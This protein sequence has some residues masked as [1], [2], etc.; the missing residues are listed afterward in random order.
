MKNFN[1]IVEY[2]FMNFDKKFI[3]DTELTFENFEKSNFKKFHDI[4][5]EELK[6]E[7]E[8]NEDKIVIKD[9]SDILS[10]RYEN[11]ILP[12]EEEYLKKSFENK[13]LYIEKF[14]V[15]LLKENKPYSYYILNIFKPKDYIHLYEKYSYILIDKI[16]KDNV[17]KNIYLND[18]NLIREANSIFTLMYF[19]QKSKNIENINFI[20]NSK[21]F[22][23][24]EGK[25]FLNIKQSN[26]LSLEEIF[27]KYKEFLIKNE[28]KL[29][30]KID[31]SYCLHENIDL[32]E[33]NKLKKIKLIT[34]QN[35]LK[36]L[37]NNFNNKKF[38]FK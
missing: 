38:N 22:F 18:I 26:Y 3:I 14:F 37:N 8:F 25:Y 24:K 21:D 16:K 19:Y 29:I 12:K 17:F 4:F 1:N 9:R 36:K 5:V 28:A 10:V 27:E 35:D 2:V 31:S 34:E 11:F 20:L 33:F 23:N 7:T 13:D 30:K 15:D 6:K 32:K